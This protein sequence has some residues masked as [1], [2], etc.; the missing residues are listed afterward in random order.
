MISPSFRG[1]L[2]LERV[3]MKAFD[4]LND[5]RLVFDAIIAE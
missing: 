5:L 2:V 3:K 1:T 4:M